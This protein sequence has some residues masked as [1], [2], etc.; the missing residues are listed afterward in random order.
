MSRRPPPAPPAPP[1]DVVRQGGN[2]DAALDDPGG[3]SLEAVTDAALSAA[4]TALSRVRPGAVAVVFADDALQSS[5]NTLY[6]GELG[7][8]NVLAFSV[9]AL[10]VEE[11]A[12]QP[13]MNGAGATNG[14]AAISAVEA[15]LSGL[16]GF[17]GEPTPDDSMLGDIVLAFETVRLEANEQGL[18]LSDHICHLVIHGYLHLQGYDHQTDDEAAIMEALERGALAAMGR[19]DPYGERGEPAGR[20]IDPDPHG[21]D[22]AWPR[23]RPVGEGGPSWPS[24]RETDRE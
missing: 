10:E 14:V 19:H 8:T 20:T 13:P 4:R 7:S 11:P 16:P 5:L 12:I 24:S 17:A 1:H 6:R 15:P 2:W 21:R 22:R 18:N 23:G 3:L 9:G